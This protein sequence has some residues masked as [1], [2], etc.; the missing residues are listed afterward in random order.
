MN[1]TIEKDA[2]VKAGNDVI[3]L[4]HF[5]DSLTD[6]FIRRVYTSGEKSYCNSFREASLRYASTFA[7]KEAIFKALKQWEEGLTI[8]W[9]QIEII[10]DK[11]A[12]KPTVN[13]FNGAGPAFDTSLSISHDGDYVWA[14]ALI[15]KTG[16]SFNS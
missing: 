3:F 11:I 13:L 14:I 16:N 6:S 4:P 2:M 10:R 7:A 1:F 15:S 5:Q 9:K 8:P 12:G